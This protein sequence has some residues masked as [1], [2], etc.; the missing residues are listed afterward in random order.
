MRLSKLLP[1]SFFARIIV[2]IFSVVLFSKAL[3]LIYLILDKEMLVDRQ[4]THGAALTLRAYW[5]ADPSQR[6]KIAAATGLRAVPL[7]ALPKTEHY[8]LYHRVF[9]A[10]MR[11]ELGENTLIRLNMKGQNAL[12]VYAPSLGPNWVMVPLYPLPLSSERI[13]DILGWFLAIGLLST[14]AAWI[15]VGQLNTPFRQLVLATRQFGQGHK[16]R[17]PI[18]NSLYELNEVHRAFNQMA[19]DIEK[20]NRER[21]LMLAGVSHDLRTPL[22]RLRLGLELIEADS[23]MVADMVRDIEDM[24][25]IL[26]QFVA[27]I[28]DGNDEL[29]ELLD[30]G[31]LIRETVAPYNQTEERVRLTVESLPE[32]S[33]RRVSIKRLLV[34]LI[35]NALHYAGKEI[36]VAAACASTNDARYLLLRVLDR[37][38]G[39]PEAELDVLFNP[40]IR[41]NT[42]RSGTGSG[43][44]LAIVR[45]IATLHGGRVELKNRDGGGLEARLYLPLG[46]L[47]PRQTD[48]RLSK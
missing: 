3:T 8:F 36:E 30:L 12:W 16:I 34:N 13:L 43:L 11:T 39:L 15:F 19:E 33:L 26:G 45:R 24:N 23:A 35:D 7:N 2:L 29:P 17:L 37:G 10:Q 6:D 20:A 21:E 27:F 41:G 28:R 32:L 1:H 18:N 47:L 22:T 48:E 44:G 38:P 42:A 25:A 46:L 31:E 14:A 40:F 5:A 4:Y 9:L